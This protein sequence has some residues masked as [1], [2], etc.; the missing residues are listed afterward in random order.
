MHELKSRHLFDLSI[1]LLPILD[2]GATPAGYRRVVPVAGGRFRGERLSGEI[3]PSTGT[4]LLLTRADGSFQQDVR[5]VLRTDDG[6]LILMT[7][8]GVRHSPPQISLRIAHGEPVPP[9]EYYLRT[10]PS[11]ETSV[12]TYAWLNHLIAVGV[13]ERLP[14]GARYDVFEIL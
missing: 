9:S 5:M 6:A 3:L 7:Y 4:D 10:T 8:R 12:P 1:E 13:G 2:L 14:N 11:F